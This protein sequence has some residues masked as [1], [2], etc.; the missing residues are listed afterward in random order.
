MRKTLLIAL[1]CSVTGLHSQVLL[2]VKQEGKWGYIDDR[3]NLKVQSRYDA[4]APFEGRRFARVTASRKVGLMNADGRE[5][6]APS[7]DEAVF[8]S[9]SLLAVCKE[10]RWGAA[11][12]SGRMLLACSYDK[13]LH[14]EK[15]FLIVRQDSL[16]RLYSLAGASFRGSPRDT[17]FPAPP[18]FITGKRLK[19]LVDT[20]GKE[21]LPQEYE[22]IQVLSSRLALFCRDGFCGAVSSSGQGTEPAYVDHYQLSPGLLMLRRDSLWCLFSAKAGRVITSQGFSSFRMLADGTVAGMQNGQQGLIDEDGRVLLPAEYQDIAPNGRTGYNVMKNNLWGLVDRSGNPL[23]PT[24]YTHIELFSGELSRVLRGGR[25]GLVS[26]EGELLVQPVHEKIDLFRNTARI[27][28]GNT[29]RVYVYD[30]GKKEIDEYRNV[31]VL[32]VGNRANNFRTPPS[33]R[34]SPTTGTGWY[35]SPKLRKWGLKNLV[36][37][38]IHIFP[39]YDNI[40]ILPDLGL[41]VVEVFD[42]GG[43]SLRFGKMHIE[44]TRLLG[45]VD[46]LTGQQLCPPML[47]AVRMSDFRKSCRAFCITARG[48]PA[49]LS[50]SGTVKTFNGGC[51]LGE[52]GDQGITA[53]NE[54]GSFLA[55]YEKD[56]SEALMSFSVFE[57]S[58]STGTNTRIR[59]TAAENN[60]ASLYFFCKGGR[61][62]YL[63]QFREV[64][65]PVYQFART[66]RNGTLIVKQGDRY[67]VL[68]L[69]GRVLL[70]FGYD[71]ISYLPESGNRLFL[72]Q[73][74]MDRYSFASREG[75]VIADL[76]YEA[77]GDFSEQ[78]ARVKTGRHW[79][80]IGLN[81]ELAVKDT[82]DQAGDFSEGLAPVRKG[83]RWGYIDREG[84]LIIKAE[85]SKAG[86][87]SEGLA[88]INAKGRY[89]YISSSNDTV[90]APVFSKAW[91][92]QEGVAR[93]KKGRKV[94]LIDRQGKWVM[95]PSYEHIGEF[96][97]SGIAVTRHHGRYGLVNI[98][99]KK[100]LPCRYTGVR[101]FSEGLACVSLNGRWGYVNEKGEAVIRPA[102]TKAGDFSEGLA[103][104][105]VKGKWGYINS[106]GELVISPRY[107]QCLDFREGRAGVYEN[108]E[109]FYIDETGER[110]IAGQR[111]RKVEGFSGN[112]ALVKDREGRSGF[113]SLDG[114]LRIKGYEEARTF[115][116]DIA[117]V[118]RNGKWGMVDET[119][120]EVLA[121]KFDAIESFKE[122]F[123]KVRV[124][125]LQGIASQSGTVILPVE[126]ETI[127]RVHQG[128]YR[129]E[130]GD[131]LGYYHS[132]KGWI[133]ELSR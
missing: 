15:G 81:G 126:Y 33:V 104:V 41:T 23:L 77:A 110:V 63:S 57:S 121:A 22:K 115:E 100:V 80:F 11:D 119:G 68:D 59:S 109:G 40:T 58:M 7:Y 95:R 85:Y 106:L 26:Q 120:Q 36:T 3:G 48:S 13:V 9:P 108:G 123:A 132:T 101:P 118:K 130:R 25:Y 117:C 4:A 17:F 87:F 6:L 74:R 70:S 37:G 20:S 10:G 56:T 90:I 97:T 28:D 27:R 99:G 82:F 19:G 51:Y 93:V 67:G 71:N 112:R 46:H 2:P 107:D 12:T 43:F 105:R 35:Y 54:G 98:R 14:P 72:L 94:G 62:G 49:I 111:F 86:S 133:H 29:L 113:I 83:H 96:S 129:V 124:S 84:D 34:S 64:T 69:Q 92:F 73:K 76:R 127:K 8:L 30:K 60:T 79:G 31:R 114:T 5:V 52:P 128:I 122:G 91:N 116:E 50:R 75:I 88:W 131:W 65:A 103:R 45:I 55:A 44:G 24:E 16:Y 61:W 53:F 1:C 38:L 89:G 21:L 66:S 78:L 47:A 42:E 18:F 39:A 125:I 102:Y 32:K